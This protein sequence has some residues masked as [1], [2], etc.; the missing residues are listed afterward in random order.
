MGEKG[1]RRAA[2]YALERV[3]PQVLAR[4]EEKPEEAYIKGETTV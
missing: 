1:Q 3:L 2:Q 4:L